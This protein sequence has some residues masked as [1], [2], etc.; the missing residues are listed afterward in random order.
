MLRLVISSF[1]LP[2]SL[3]LVFSWRPFWLRASCSS[4]LSWLWLLVFLRR[5]DRRGTILVEGHLDLPWRC[6]ILGYELRRLTGGIGVIWFLPGEVEVAQ[7]ALKL[8]KVP[9]DEGIVCSLRSQ[10]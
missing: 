8:I 4:W 7:F 10:L 6:F 1:S 5:R 9:K 3:A 2:V